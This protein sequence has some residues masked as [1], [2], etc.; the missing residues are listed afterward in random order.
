MTKLGKTYANTPIESFNNYNYIKLGKYVWGGTP[1]YTFSIDPAHPWL[2]IHSSTGKITGTPTSVTATNPSFT[3]KVTDA[4]TSASFT[5]SVDETLP[6]RADISTVRATSDIK[7]PKL[8]DVVPEANSFN[9]SV[10]EG[11]PAYI[12]YVDWEMYNEEMDTWDYVYDGVKFKEGKWRYVVYVDLDAPDGYNNVL[13]ENLELYLDG[14]ALNREFVSI[15]LSESFAK[16]Y[17]K[18]FTIADTIKIDGGGGGYGS[19]KK[20]TSKKEDTTTTTDT[21]TTSDTPI[22]DTQKF[23]DVYAGSWYYDAV[24]YVSE[25]GLMVGTS[26]NTFSPTGTATR[27]MIVTILHRLEG[28]PRFSGVTFSDVS[29]NIYCAE[30]VKWASENNIVSGY[31]NNTFGPNDPITRE[32]MA[33]IFMR[34]SQFKGDDISKRVDISAYKDVSKISPWAKDAVS[35]ANAVGLIAG[36]GT[37]LN[38]SSKATRAE[39]AAFFM[40]YLENY[41]K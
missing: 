33:A 34:Y 14:V 41:D 31:G 11:G 5:F 8:G 27:G 17:S 16:F 3:V 30:A 1:P 7:L 13:D 35:W 6:E 9:F 20:S 37:N 10:Y 36:D 21:P 28:S 32:Q 39:I 25:K 22:A 19:I 23:T 40:K 2:K 38:P 15:R 26:A 29:E 4:T 24:K 12:K 18:E